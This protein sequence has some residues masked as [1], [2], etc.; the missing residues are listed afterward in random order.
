MSEKP[1]P[2][3]LFEV[4]N[5]IG[6]VSQLSRALLESRLPD[7]FIEAHFSV[8]NHL[9]RLGDG[10]TPIQIARAFQVPKTSM[11]HTLKV[12][13]Q[14]GMITMQP[15]PDD[16]RSKQ[17]NLTDA[18]RQLRQDVVAQ[19]GQDFAVVGQMFGVDR[20]EGMLPDLRALRVF[21]DENRDLAALQAKATSDQG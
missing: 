18:G 7:G 15:N 4:F 8:L 12:L 19:L 17:V 16:G 9:V 21:L 11:T 1:N 13:E 5:E 3:R 14:R 10:R 2:G 20:F 6:I